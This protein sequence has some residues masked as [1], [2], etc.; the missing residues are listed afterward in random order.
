MM[1]TPVNSIG[2]PESRSGHGLTE[3]ADRERQSGFGSSG[4]PYGIVFERP[5]RARFPEERIASG[6]LVSHL[7]HGRQASEGRRLPSLVVIAI[8]GRPINFDA[9]ARLVRKSKSHRYSL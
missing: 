8:A 3:S 5:E 2:N 4:G 6:A 1:R 7:E 9:R